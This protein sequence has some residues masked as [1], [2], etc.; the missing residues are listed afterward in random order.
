MKRSLSFLATSAVTLVMLHGLCSRVMAAPPDLTAG[1]V[2]NEDPA[3]TIN[4]GAT[5]AR[6]WI[7]SN[8]IYLVE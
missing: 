4:L 7:Y 2:P 8:P 1:G 3:V 6:G 5:G